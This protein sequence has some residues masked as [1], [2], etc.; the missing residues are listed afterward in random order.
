MTLACGA[1]ALAVSGSACGGTRP[2]ARMGPHMAAGGLLTM[3]FSGVGWSFAGGG[4]R[5]RGRDGERL[6]PVGRDHAG[7]RLPGSGTVSSIATLT[8]PGSK[9]VNLVTFSPDGRTLATAD[10]TAA[11]PV[12][13]GHPYPAS[14]PG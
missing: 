4:G 11:L 13:R 1:L 9:N 6:R 10:Q 14:P 3:R 2:D 8:D 5:G 12:G 7:L